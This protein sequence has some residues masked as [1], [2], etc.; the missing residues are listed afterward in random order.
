MKNTKLIW[1]IEEDAGLQEQY[2]RAFGFYYRLRHVYT[3]SQLIDLLK[4]RA[5]ES[6]NPAL[7]ISEVKFKDGL[8]VEAKSFKDIYDPYL[9]KTIIISSS[10][11]KDMIRFCLDKDIIDYLVKPINIAELAVKVEN[12]MSKIREWLPDYPDGEDFVMNDFAADLTLTERQ[13][14]YLFFQ[15]KDHRISREYIH[16]RVWKESVVNPKTLDVHIFNLRKK[17]RPKGYTIKHADGHWNL[18]KDENNGDPAD[19]F[20]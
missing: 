14:L 17:L 5:I 16:Q 4:S 18:Q 3:F 12:R 15:S 20:T 13:I 8:L 1:L 7:I 19:K 9:K 2:A 6:E 10:D 11:D